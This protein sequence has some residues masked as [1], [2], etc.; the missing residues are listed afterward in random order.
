MRHRGLALGLLNTGSRVGAAM[1]LS[2]ASFIALAV[3]WRA[4]FVAFGAAGA[5]W[6]AFWYATFRDSP[7]GQAGPRPSKIVPESPPSI[8]GKW[9]I[10][11]RSV[12][13]YLVIFQ[14]FACNFTI[15]LCF[16][17]LLPYMKARFGLTSAQAGVY[18]SLPFYCGAVAAYTGGLAVD[19]LYKRGHWLLSRRLPPIFGLGLAAIC[20]AA[21][22]S[23]P[24]TAAFLICVCLAAFGADFTLSASWTVCSDIG[25]S[26]TATISGAM[27]MVG[28][29]GGFASAVAFPYFLGLTGNVRT[30]FYV[31]A[32]LNIAAIFCWV[33]IDPRQALGEPY[34]VGR[35]G[36][37]KGNPG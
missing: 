30:F 19:S 12:N 8:P 4:A 31:A 6:A 13:F 25:G 14:Y 21:L 7:P 10:F 9:S 28:S 11:L 24:T 29:L 18:A 5:V 16:S 26:S 36:S 32:L 1:G 27:N 34:N 37:G 15:F 2:A 3:G 23:M 17:W 20:V 33:R 22:P 35:P